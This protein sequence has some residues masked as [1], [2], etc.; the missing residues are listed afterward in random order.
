MRKKLFITLAF[1]LSSFTIL[2]SQQWVDQLST[3]GLDSI[4]E[5]RIDI[6]RYESAI[7]AYLRQPLNHQEAESDT[8]LQ[9]IIIRHRGFDKPV[10]FVTEG[11]AAHYALW[12][13]YDEELAEALD[14]NLIVA[15][16]R[17]FGNSTPSTIEWEQLNLYNAT[18][19]LH[20]INQLLKTYYTGPWVSTGIS[21]GG[22]TCLYY[23][24]FYPDDVQASVPYVAPL[25]FSTADKRVFRFLR[26]VAN[27]ECRDKLQALQ[28]DLLERRS[29]FYPMFADSA[30]ARNFSF[31]WVGGTEKAYEYNV[32]EL[33][34]AYWQWYPVSC[35]ALP[36]P[37]SNIDT[38]FNTFIA[39]AG[40]DF[41]SD[42]SIENFQPFF[43]QAL[44]EMGFYSYDIKPFKRLLHLVH[45]PNFNHTLPTG[46]SVRY[47]PQ[48][49]RK[50]D[51]WLKRHGDR[52]LYVYGEYDA[53]SSTAVKPGTKT[54]HLKLILP[55]GSHTT[56]LRHF[57]EHSRNEAISMLKSWINL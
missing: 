34:F 43:Y 6:R 57:D 46:I 14:A 56:R 22:Q 35:D 40:Y 48:L 36:L 24:Y 11:Y 32:L 51:G 12:P 17:F 53:W 15:E 19:D 44:T 3:L 27:P 9:R 41:F 16:H 23:R 31:D 18:A 7:V 38:V 39:A 30:K 28:K 5:L 20:S 25:N 10:V 37:G 8:F 42:Q 55:E 29:V 26:S 54:D 50:V 2:F 45:H 1:V 4:K 33:G 47:S 21:K 13:R 52:I 49:S